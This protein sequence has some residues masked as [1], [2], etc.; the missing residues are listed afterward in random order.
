MNQLSRDCPLRC[1]AKFT[2]DRKRTERR[3]KNG[4]E[5]KEENVDV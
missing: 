5:E 2:N 3:K 1:E 4:K